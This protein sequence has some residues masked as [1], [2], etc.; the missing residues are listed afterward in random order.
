MKICIYPLIEQATIDLPNH[1]EEVIGQNVTVNA[2][3]S[4]GSHITLQKRKKST[5]EFEDICEG[6]YSV[7]GS[8]I[9]IYSL[10]AGDKGEYRA[11]VYSLLV[12]SN[13]AC[14]DFIITVTGM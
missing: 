1:I 6:K 4:G 7:S 8:T 12:P 14:T 9:T 5:G 13:T 10:S 3:V 11:C 2:I